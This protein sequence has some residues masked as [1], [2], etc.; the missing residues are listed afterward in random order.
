M[1]DAATIVAELRASLQALDIEPPYVLVGHS[2]GGTY[3]ELYARSY[4]EEVAG[5]VF[6]DSRHADF[7][8]QCKLADAG[9]C[10]P[11]ALALA[12]MPPGPKREMDSAAVTMHQVLNRI[13]EWQ[14]V[15]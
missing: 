14:A 13:D 6:V 11:P 1:R 5:V 7:T 10:E 12:L 3:M 4:P 9:G 15:S 2:I 8:R